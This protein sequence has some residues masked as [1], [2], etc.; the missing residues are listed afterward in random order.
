MSSTPLTQKGRA[1]ILSTLK[2]LVPERHINVSSLNQDYGRWIA[3]VDERMPRLIDVDNTEAFETGVSELLRALGSSHTAFYHER[4]D[5]V[6][7]PNNLPDLLKVN[8]KVIVNH[9]VPESRNRAPIHLQAL[10]LQALGEPSGGFGQRLQV[11]KDS[12]LGLF[13][14][15]EEFFAFVSIFSD[16][17][18]TLQNMLEIRPIILHKG[19][20]SL[21]TRSRRYA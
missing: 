8:A 15:E 7:A 5:S 18:D 4:H 13:V 21:R 2:E 10:S 16:P 3:L 19:T 14:G 1:K 12:V 17:I 11:S 6:S 20:A 9:N